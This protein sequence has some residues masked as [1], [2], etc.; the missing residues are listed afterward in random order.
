VIALVGDALVRLTPLAVDAWAMPWTVAQWCVFVPWMLFMAYSEGYRGFQTMFAPRVVARAAT[1]IDDPQPVRVLFAPLFVMGLFGA[2][3]KRKIVARILVV[4][5]VALIVLV[6]L[7]PQ[8]W[9]GIVDAGV[10]LGLGWGTVAMVVCA[11]RALT[12]R[13]PEIDPD[14]PE[15]A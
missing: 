2:T 6:R 5:I 14:L 3:R 10:V 1:L 11:A 12:G 8:P 4:G 9:R 13:P 7:L 15:R